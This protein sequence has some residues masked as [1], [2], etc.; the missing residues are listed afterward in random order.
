MVQNFMLQ[1]IFRMH[2]ENYQKLKIAVEINM[3]F[4]LFFV[5]VLSFLVL[6]IA[7]I[8]PVNNKSLFMTFSLHHSCNYTRIAAN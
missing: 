7:L 3:N 5:G 1:N 8:A 2:F 6:R 4:I